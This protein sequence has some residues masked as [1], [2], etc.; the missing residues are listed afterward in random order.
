MPSTINAIL[1]QYWGYDTFRSLQQNIIESVLQGKDTLALLP[2]GGGKSICFQVPAMARSGLCLVVSPLIAL[3]KDQVQNLKK[4]GI[5]AVAIYGTMPIY[6]I[7]RILDNCIYSKDIKFLYVS[8]ERLQSDLFKERLKKMPINLVAIDEAHCVSQWGYDFRPAYLKIA[9]LR[10]LLPPNIPFL[11]LTATATPRVKDD[12]CK[13]LQ[14][15]KARIFVKSFQRANLCYAVEHSNQ[16]IEKAIEIL[17]KKQGCAIVY[18]RSRQRVQ[19]LA[20]AIFKKGIKADY[21]HAGLD[22]Q[23]RSFKQDEWIQNRIRVM[24]CTNAF[25]MGIDKPDVRL[26]I[27]IEPPDSIEAYYQEAGRAGRDEQNALALLLYNE[28]DI[29]NL[30]KNAANYIPPLETIK[31]VYQAL[32]NYLQIATGAGAGQ[33]YDFDMKLF[34]NAFNLQAPIAYQALRILEQSEYITLTDAIV[35]PSKVQLL[36]NNEQL[37][38]LYIKQPRLE[39]YIKALL[40]NYGGA[41]YDQHVEIS[42]II[43]AQ[44]I[45]KHFNYTTSEAYTKNALNVMA[46][47]QIIAYIPYNS[48]PQIGFLQARVNPERLHLDM[49]RLGFIKKVHEHNVAAITRYVQNQ[50][51]CRTQTLVAYFGEENAPNCGVCDV[52]ISKS[53]AKYTINTL[54]K[55]QALLKTILPPQGLFINDLIK[56]LNKNQQLALMPGFNDQAIIIAIRHLADN[57]DILIDQERHVK[58]RSN[59]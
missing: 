54:E 48:K 30:Q 55:I 1:K 16:K 29:L 35:V 37:Y 47:N 57:G 41:L 5:K 19:Q 46:N 21:Y 52:C 27:H 59:K 3:M 4:R 23:T 49:D 44:F 12:I 24:V 25:G 13:Y 22:A 39:P 58:P 2:T 32:A 7:D 45:S 34:C 26:V 17:Q 38:K 10:D 42:E 53:N 11:A 40:Q 14:L 20:E 8:P 15:K 43:I 36:Y 28:A 56:A 31:Q 6:E 51:D 50:Q 33:S 18:A 9:E